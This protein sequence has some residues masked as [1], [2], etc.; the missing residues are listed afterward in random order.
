MGSMFYFYAL[1]FFEGM[2]LLP[3][4]L[5]TRL[6][7]VKRESTRS[8]LQVVLDCFGYV[9]SKA[10]ILLFRSFGRRNYDSCQIVRSYLYRK[11]TRLGAKPIEKKKKVLYSRGT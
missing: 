4:F 9:L 5:L 1:G 7:C 8:S 6:F 2:L 3:V 10:F 11:K